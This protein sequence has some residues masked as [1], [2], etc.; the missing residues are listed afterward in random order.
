MSAHDLL[1]QLLQLDAELRKEKRNRWQRDLPF[2][3][4]AFDRWERARSLGFGAESSVYHNAYLY[5]DVK[6]GASTWV[7]PFVLLDGVGGL[8]IGSNCSISAGVHIYTHDTVRWALSGGAAPRE[9]GP[10]T[11]GDCTYVGSQTVITKGVSVGHHCVIAANSVVTADVDPH[12]V[13]AGVPARTIGSVSLASDGSISID[14]S[15][16]G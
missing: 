10:V 3:E 16:T 9:T 12:S 15:G 13:V 6:I 1:A 11:V 8:T 14:T 7:G 5:G 2:D 4:L